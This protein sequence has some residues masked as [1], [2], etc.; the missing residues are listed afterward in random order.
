MLLPLR[1]VGGGPISRKIALR[2][3]WM[4]PNLTSLPEFLEYIYIEVWA[5]IIKYVCI[6]IHICETVQKYNSALWI[7]QN[8]K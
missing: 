1:G 6:I 7:V 2:N 4:A 5:F 3:T 8:V